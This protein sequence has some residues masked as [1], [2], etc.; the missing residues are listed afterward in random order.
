MVRRSP[1]PANA[2]PRHGACCYPS[3]V[4]AAPESRRPP[5]RRSRRPGPEP[6]RGRLPLAVWFVLLA[7]LG[8]LGWRLLEG[9]RLTK[10]TLRAAPRAEVPAPE[11]ALTFYPDQLAFTA[12]SPPP[13]LGEAKLPAGG[14]VTVGPDLVPERALVRYQGAGVGTGFLFVASGREVPIALEPPGSLWGR[15]VTPRPYWWFGWR[16]CSAPVVGADVLAMGGGEHGVP[17]VAATT[18]ADGSFEIDGLAVKVSP[19]AMR[20]RAPGFALV[21][22]PVDLAQNA[23]GGHL[24]RLPAAPLRRGTVDAPA[25]CDR[26]AL[27]VLAR[28]LPGVHTAVAADGTFALDHVPAEL[29][30]E[31]LVLGLPR[32][33]AQQRTFAWRD[34][35]AHVVVEPGGGLR[36][37]VRDANTGQPLPGSYVWFGDGQSVVADAYGRFQLD[38]LV[39]GTNR[40][41]AQYVYQ[42]KNRR[43]IVRLGA[44]EVT[45][46][47]GTTVA[48]L[49]V[50]IP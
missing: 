26:S 1:Y 34:R 13:P 18:Q 40:L 12:V 35:P 22:A 32:H 7:L 6:N 19:L 37:V 20:V 11:L 36:G 46:V 15:V 25:D 24:V 43:P 29:E 3:G 16:S 28:G 2:P 5:P 27:A 21:H 23:R 48:D 17:L 47:A 41:S 50:E 4:S 8:L 49:V 42:P 44:K 38:Q 14:E 10:V 45:V 31:L 30:P 9:D 39:P 33:F